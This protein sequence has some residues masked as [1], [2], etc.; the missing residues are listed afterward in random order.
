[1]RVDLDWA[2]AQVK[3]RS[4]GMCEGCGRYGLVLDAHH[5]QA[6]GMGGVS[7][8]EATI[9]NSVTNLL[10]LCRDCHNETEHAETWALT[11]GLGWRIPKWVPDPGAVPA[12]I[13][14]V[15]GHAWWILTEDVGYKWINFPDGYA[16]TWDRP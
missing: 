16:I 14:T 15:N 12:W 10:A 7:G 8:V 2:K 6:R 4:H 9:A 3:A 1:V 5:R 11:E 13:Y